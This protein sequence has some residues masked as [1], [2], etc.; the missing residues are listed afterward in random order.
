MKIIEMLAPVGTNC[1]PGYALFP[2]YIT[3]HN[4]AN[5]AKG[6]NAVNH[7]K[8]LQGSGA[9]KYVSY[10]YAVDDAQTVRIIPE[11]E[12]AWHA[13]DGGNG[14]GNR[15]SLAIEICENSD[16][17]L[18]KATDNAAQLTAGLMQKFGIGI[19]HIV[20]H[21]H[22]SG[23]DCPNR[24]RKGQPYSWETFLQKVQ[25]FLT[26]VLPAPLSA[27]AV[28]MACVATGADKLPILDKLDGLCIA[29]H[30]DGNSILT[31]VAV[32]AGDQR[33]LLAVA[34]DGVVWKVYTEPVPTKPVQQPEILPQEP[35][36]AEPDNQ[37]TEEEKAEN[38][39][40]KEPVEDVPL[41]AENLAILDLIDRAVEE[42]EANVQAVRSRK[43]AEGM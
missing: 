26:P 10:H 43:K 14:Q 2:T 30:V 25:A 34:P 3:I 28:R 24:L 4:T 42:Y 13:G 6:A 17:D 40:K 29:Y 27:N 22:W 20:Q 19:D 12:V 7:A 11:N 37:S 16:G 18:L 39:T 36:K 38:S 21:N 32:T 5:T 8:Y 9:A 1:R 23:K 15:H 35:S 33:S 31:D 41:T